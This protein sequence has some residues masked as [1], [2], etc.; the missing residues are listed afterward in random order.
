MNE[1]IIP[2]GFEI[3]QE[4]ERVLRHLETMD[5]KF[6]FETQNGKIRKLTITG[7]TIHIPRIIKK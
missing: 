2:E 4:E 7:N 5:C 3:D 6:I 1:Q